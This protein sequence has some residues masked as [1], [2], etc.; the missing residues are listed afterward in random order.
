MEDLTL[1]FLLQMLLL[2]MLTE[3][4]E[5][6]SNKYDTETDGAA[7]EWRKEVEEEENTHSSV[8]PGILSLSRWAFMAE[9]CSFALLWS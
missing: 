2:L 8:S 7:G 3:L 1:D 4:T 5:K 6:D 9:L